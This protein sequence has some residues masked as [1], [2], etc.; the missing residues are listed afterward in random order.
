MP[1]R[2]TMHGCCS[3]CSMLASCLN[4]EKLREASIDCRCFNIVSERAQRERERR[5][6]ERGSECVCTWNMDNS[7]SQRE[8]GR[9]RERRRE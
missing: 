4:S 1:T 2:G 3:E 9:Q 6:K 8:K 7:M 5:G